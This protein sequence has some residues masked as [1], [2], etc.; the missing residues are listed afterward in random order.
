[1]NLQIF[2]NLFRS[3]NKRSTKGY[4]GLLLDATA[5]KVV[6]IWSEI[7][8]EC[9]IRLINYR[10][11][12]NYRSSYYNN[13]AKMAAYLTCQSLSG[14]PLFV[15]R[16]GDVPSVG[17]IDWQLYYNI[18]NWTN[19]SSSQLLP[20]NGSIC[21][22][23]LPFPLVASL[24]GVHTFLKNYDALLDS[25]Q[26]TNATVVWK[27]YHNT[28]IFCIVA[29]D[30]SVSER[31]L[32]HLLD[33]ILDSIIFLIGTE[34]LLNL[35]NIERSKKELKVSY[36]DAD[37]WWIACIDA[38]ILST[39]V[40]PVDRF[41]IGH[42]ESRQ[43]VGIFQWPDGQC[44]C[45][46]LFG[47]AHVWSKTRVRFTRWCGQVCNSSLVSGLQGI[48]NCSTESI[49][50]VFGC[51]NIHGKIAAATANWW[52]LHPSELL[53]IQLFLRND[54]SSTGIDV[55]IYLPVRSPKIPFRLVRWKLTHGSDVCVLCGPT[56]SLADLEKELKRF[57]RSAFGL[58]KS[59]E[60]SYPANSPLDVTLDKNIL[61]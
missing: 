44:G 56:P 17:F 32:K 1:M 19:D 24:N 50:T 34:E 36:I 58:L 42:A 47:A 2:Y 30:S 40:L 22:L 8:S 15:R 35:K 33:T 59:A 3:P 53:Q 21:L 16:K 45:C 25:T 6:I 39:D 23:Q 51:L 27:E 29:T 55:P 10:Y 20:I 12:A 61:S 60:S 5:L 37:T 31:H 49:G 28:F 11:P 54:V 18:F 46:Q 26:T 13:N 52:T 14:L 38:F 7:S 9:G 43:W 41:D 48:L 4:R 57:W